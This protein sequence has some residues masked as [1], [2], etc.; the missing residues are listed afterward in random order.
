ML[1]EAYFSICS[2][3]EKSAYLNRSP[4]I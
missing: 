3:K 4:Y 2:T 1:I